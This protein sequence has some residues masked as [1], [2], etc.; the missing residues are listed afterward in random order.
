MLSLGFFAALRRSELAGLPVDHL[1]LVEQGLRVLIGKS[2]RDPEGT[3]R[4]VDIPYAPPELAWLCPIRNTLAWLDATGRREYLHRTGQPR[5]ATVPL[6]SGLTRGA[7]VRLTA[8][9][10]AV[11]ADIVKAAVSDAGQPAEI[12]AALGGHSLRAGFATAADKAGV[13]EATSGRVLGHASSM[14]GRYVRHAFDGA[15]QRAIYEM[16]RSHTP[17]GTELATSVNAGGLRAPQT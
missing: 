6:L 14:T 12:V 13:Q 5:T 15:A 11:V 2:K 16:A 8:L 1:Q 17:S 7:T 3:G 10:P 9:S 4:I